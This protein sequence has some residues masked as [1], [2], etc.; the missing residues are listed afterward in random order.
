MLEHVDTVNDS[1]LEQE[2]VIASGMPLVTL[3]SPVL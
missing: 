1:S 3:E 2:P